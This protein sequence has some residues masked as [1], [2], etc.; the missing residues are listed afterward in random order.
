MSWKALILSLG[1]EQTVTA[2]EHFVDGSL[3]SELVILMTQ[4]PVYGPG[5]SG[6]QGW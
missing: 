4:G 6:H 2:Q 5:L 1:F 3:K